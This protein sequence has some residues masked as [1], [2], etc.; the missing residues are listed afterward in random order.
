MLV[1]EGCELWAREVGQIALQ[2]SRLTDPALARTVGEAVTRIDAVLARLIQPGSDQ[3]AAPVTPEVPVELQH[4]TLPRVARLLIRIE[5]A[6]IHM[7]AARA[8]T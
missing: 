5:A 8:N 3:P 6:L 4:D 2:G 7:V 1:L